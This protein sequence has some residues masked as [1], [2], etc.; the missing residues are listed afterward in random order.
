MNDDGRLNEFIKDRLEADISVEPPRME[1][2]VEAASRAAANRKVA[3]MSHTRIWGGAMAA[4]A[5]AAI[6]LFTVHMQTPQ[7]AETGEPQ[8]Q[9]NYA[10]VA[11]MIDLLRTVDGYEPMQLEA[12]GDDSIA[13]KMLA[14]QD[15]PYEQAISGLFE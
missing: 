12:T 14:W 13:D 1:A 11:D 3:R 6:C 5:L 4:A 7:R 2:I 9:S 8:N 10:V 15:A